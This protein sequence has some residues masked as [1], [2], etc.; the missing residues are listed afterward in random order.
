MRFYVDDVDFFT[1]LHLACRV[2]KTMWTALDAHQ[3]LIAADTAENHKQFDRMSL[4]HVYLARRNHAAG[5][6][7]DGDL[8]AQH[9]RIP[10]D[11]FRANGGTVEVRAP[12]ATLE[13]LT[14]LLR[15]LT[16]ERPQVAL[17]I[18]VYQISHNFTREIGMHIPNTFNLYN[19]P[20][21][22]AGGAGRDRAFSRSSTN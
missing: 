14:R 4:G 12:Q 17:D 20:A 6:H 18:E 5:S 8:P 11:Q 21:A 22:S 10:E 13:A 7:R 2:S 16:T 1:A 15:Q 19:I 9:L 3:V